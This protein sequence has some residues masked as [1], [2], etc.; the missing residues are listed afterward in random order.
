MVSLFTADINASDRTTSY[1]VVFNN[2]RYIFQPVAN[3]TG[4][5]FS[6]TREHDEWQV[7][8][9]VDKDVQSQ[10]IAKLESYLLAQL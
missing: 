9:N 3:S 1:H 6:V 4:T 2:G 7:Q 8:G 10:A 5:E